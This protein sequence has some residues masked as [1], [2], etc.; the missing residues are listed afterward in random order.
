[1]SGIGQIVPKV[2]EFVTALAAT[3]QPNDPWFIRYARSFAIYIGI[4]ALAVMGVLSVY[5]KSDITSGAVCAAL[6][7]ILQQFGAQ[8]SADNQAQILADTENKKTITAAATADKQTD[9]IARA[10]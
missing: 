1:M 8:R 4:L 2:Q 5:L 3:P 7:V 9:A 10:A 6:S